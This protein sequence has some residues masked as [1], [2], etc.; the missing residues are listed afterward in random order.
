ML[1][2]DISNVLNFQRRLLF[3]HSNNHRCNSRT[4]T[5]AVIW[6][7]VDGH[8]V[9][10]V[11]RSKK[12]SSA[13]LV[14]EQKA[15]LKGCLSSHYSAACGDCKRKIYKNTGSVCKRYHSGNICKTYQRANYI[16]LRTS[17]RAYLPSSSYVRW[18]V[19]WNR[20]DVSTCLATTVLCTWSRYG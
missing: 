4:H 2:D 16:S 7:I 11:F 13:L 5:S 6:R 15:P 19:L 8:I 18:R 1:K 10:D 14:H 17:R 12:S 9:T 3:A 20:D